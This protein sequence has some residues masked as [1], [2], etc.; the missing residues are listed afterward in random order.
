MSAE[1]RQDSSKF[2]PLSHSLTHS[3]TALPLLLFLFLFPQLYGR[4]IVAPWVPTIKG[5]TDT[6]HF[7]PE[8][9]SDDSD[10]EEYTADASWCEDF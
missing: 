7:D 4:N 2:R 6:T 10:T 1:A 3:L 8:D 9:A 5:D